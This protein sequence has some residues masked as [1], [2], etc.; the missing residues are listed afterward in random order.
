MAY[1]FEGT[2]VSN[3]QSSIGSHVANLQGPSGEEATIP[4]VDMLLVV[5]RVYKISVD[6]EFAPKPAPVAA[7]PEP[8]KP[9]VPGSAA[10]AYSGPNRRVKQAAIPYP[11]V[12]RRKVK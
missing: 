5:G 7:K 9:L 3:K 12:E 6:G 11:G 1:T 10:A 2:C 4:S 8:A